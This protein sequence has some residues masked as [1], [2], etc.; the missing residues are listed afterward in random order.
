MTGKNSRTGVTGY[1]GG[2][3]LFALEE[4]HPEYE[5][6]AIVRDSSKGAVIASQYPKVRLVYGSISDSKI[7]EE[8]SS[9]ADI[10]IRTFFFPK[11]IVTRK[12]TI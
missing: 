4:A 9:K 5:Y 10:V 2:D 1:I 11:N 3:I 6:T 12:L 8:E 7:L